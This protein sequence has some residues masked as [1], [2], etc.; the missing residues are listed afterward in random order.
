MTP[1]ALAKARGIVQEWY[2]HKLDS[3]GFPY[4][5]PLIDRVAA[6]L[7]VQA[8]EIERL[9]ELMATASGQSIFDEIKQKDAAIAVLR[10]ALKKYGGHKDRCNGFPAS[11]EEQLAKNCDCGWQ[12]IISTT[13]PALLA[14]SQDC[15]RCNG[16]GFVWSYFSQDDIDGEK[17][18]CPDCKLDGGANG[19]I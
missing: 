17:K 19:T 18:P 3:G 11:S 7:D 5:D 15:K 10:E 4:L 16:N 6:A 14:R 13:S 8:K 12:S 9:K 1:D 2:D